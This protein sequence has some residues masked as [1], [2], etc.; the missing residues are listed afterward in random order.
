M[1]R[2]RGS[3]VRCSK[4]RIYRDTVVIRK[5]MRTS[6]RRKK[7]ASVWDRKETDTKR[8]RGK[9]GG[10]RRKREREREKSKRFRQVERKSGGE[11]QNASSSRVHTLTSFARSANRSVPV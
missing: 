2:G 6:L 10:K 9:G 3:H 4:N 1:G 8:K 7:G 5:L 11:I